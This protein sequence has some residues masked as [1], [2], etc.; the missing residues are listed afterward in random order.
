MQLTLRIALCATSPGQGEFESFG[1]VEFCD[2]RSGSRL[3]GCV[4][5]VFVPGAFVD[6]EEGVGEADKRAEF[7]RMFAKRREV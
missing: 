2:S 4:E 6:V 3:V 5:C 7:R 1:L